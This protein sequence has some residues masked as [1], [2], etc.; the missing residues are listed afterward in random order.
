MILPAKSL[1]AAALFAFTA[2]GPLSA[3][4]PA[5]AN[6][7]ETTTEEEYT[8]SLGQ[9]GK[10]VIWLPTSQALVDQMLDMANLTAEDRLVDLGSGDGRL[11][12]TAAKRGAAARGIEYNPD[13]VAVS[14][15][16]AQAEG[17]GDKVTFEQADIFE[18]D[19]SDASVVTLFLLPKLNMR[20]RPTLLDMKP[21]TRVVSNSFAME[22]WEPDETAEVKE[23]CTNYCHAY[24]WTIPAKVAGKWQL[25]D[26]ELILN[27][28]F[29]ML[30]GTISNGGASTPITDARL[31]GENI[32]FS[33]NG[34][35]YTGKVNNRQMQGTINGT[36]NWTAKLVSMQ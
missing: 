2:S 22:D 11:V 15:R 3:Q 33:A 20:L 31:D 19:F 28:Q 36:S 13:M 21:G 4:T 10:D 23:G 16:T 12:I 34:Q 25:G 8:P 26:R 18:S 14:K 1:L 5:P 35:T 7:P 27:Q 24:K 30:E 6:T 32:T 17:V 9:Q 29:Q